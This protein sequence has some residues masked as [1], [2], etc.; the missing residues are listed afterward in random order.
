MAGI[1]RL[2]VP[3]APVL[4]SRGVCWRVCQ[5]EPV[6]HCT[7]TLCIGQLYI[8][9]EQTSRSYPNTKKQQLKR[10]CAEAGHVLQLIFTLSAQ[11]LYKRRMCCLGHKACVHVLD[12]RQDFI[13]VLLVSGHRLRGQDPS[14]RPFHAYVLPY[15]RELRRN[16]SRKWPVVL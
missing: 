1:I 15:S 12:F 2:Q 9:D 3:S 7:H 13:N 6:P 16:R 5:A 14:F 10:S 4:D 11:R 8:W